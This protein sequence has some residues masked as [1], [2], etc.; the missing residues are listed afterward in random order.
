MLFEELGIFSLNCVKEF[1]FEFIDMYRRIYKGLSRDPR[2]DYQYLFNVHRPVIPD[3][4]RLFENCSFH[5]EPLNLNTFNTFSV[6]SVLNMVS[7]DCLF[8][9]NNNHLEYPVFLFKF[10]P[11]FE[12]ISFIFNIFIIL[13]T[14]ICLMLIVTLI[15]AALTLIERKFLALTQ[16]R[17][18][19]YYVGYRGRLQYIADALKLFLK[20]ATVHNEANK[21]WFYA[22]PSVCCVICYFF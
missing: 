8:L 13:I 16:R 4:L 18:G 7:Q 17:V 6:F 1:V 9:L 20:G 2:V 3:L 10:D 14:N 11:I 22:V 12:K 21:F 5:N 19:P 15:I